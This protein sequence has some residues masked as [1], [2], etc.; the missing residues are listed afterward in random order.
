MAA[1]FLEEVF[2]V[3]ELFE[4]AVGLAEEVF[5]ASEGAAEGPEARLS[6]VRTVPKC[7]SNFITFRF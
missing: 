5:E 6:R 4:G 2:V 7:S 1:E 3:H